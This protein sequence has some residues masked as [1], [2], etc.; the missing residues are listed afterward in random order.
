M[1]RQNM[2]Q[3]RAIEKNEVDK[4]YDMMGLPYDPGD[5][6]LKEFAGTIMHEAGIKPHSVW[7]TVRKNCWESST[8][9][10]SATLRFHFRDLGCKKQLHQWLVKNKGKMHIDEN[11]S[12]REGSYVTGRWTQTKLVIEQIVLNANFNCLKHHLGH[13]VVHHETPGAYKDDRLLCIRPK[14]STYPIVQP[15]FDESV[16]EPSV[17][18]D[19]CTETPELKHRRVLKESR[20]LVPRGGRQ[21]A[22][23]NRR[24]T[25]SRR[26]QQTNQF[27][28]HRVPLQKTIHPGTTGVEG[29]S[30]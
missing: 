6:Q 18:H 26:Q 27:R 19:I 8:N 24:P 7:N 16:T 14:R 30:P 11:G 23:E 25:A 17:T 28:K 12:T 29:T 22:Q 1:I 3:T 20:R 13:E 10:Y 9:K 21:Q 5:W 2:A 4:T 15:A